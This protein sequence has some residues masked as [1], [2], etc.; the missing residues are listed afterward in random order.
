MNILADE[1]GR[2]IVGFSVPN[3]KFD[4]CGRAIR[5]TITLFSPDKEFTQP[6][7]DIIKVFLKEGKESFARGK[8]TLISPAI[9]DDKTWKFDWSAN[10]DT[11]FSGIQ[12]WAKK[13]TITDDELKF[14]DKISPQNPQCILRNSMF[15]PDHLEDMKQYIHF[16]D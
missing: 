2:K 14:L 5:A 10:Y 7:K 8:D 16:M 15:T 13:F 3:K 12:A 1:N 6:Q 4:C 11:L 9:V